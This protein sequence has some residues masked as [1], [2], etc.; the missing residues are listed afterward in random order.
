MWNNVD[1]MH[2]Y[3]HLKVE[4][5]I[6]GGSDPHPFTFGR[7]KLPQK[8]E[9]INFRSTFRPSIVGQMWIR[10]TV[11][12][13]YIPNSFLRSAFKC[14]RTLLRSRIPPSDV[15]QMWIRATKFHILSMPWGGGACRS[16]WI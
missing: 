12:P 6:K 2:F 15:T 3:S 8:G 9:R 1:L 11:D 13:H 16:M 7:L 5:W 14:E 4:M 10:S